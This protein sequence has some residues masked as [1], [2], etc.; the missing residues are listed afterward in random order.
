MPV[1]AA[2]APEMLER[3]RAATASARVRVAF[4]N[5]HTLNLARADPALRAAIGNCEFVLNDGAGLA[6]AARLQGR[7]FPANLHGSAFS[8]EILRLAADEGWPAFLLGGR[9]GVAECA[10]E[11]LSERIPGLRI[12][13][14][15]HGFHADAAGDVRAVGRSGARAL[16]VAMGNPLQELWLE[17]HFPE[18]PSVRLGAGVGAFLDFQAGVVRR[19]P[20]WMNRCG[21]EWTF[22]LAQEPRRLCGRYV[23]GNPRFLAHVIAERLRPATEPTGGEPPSPERAVA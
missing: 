22:R 19:S 2:S 17:S 7:R 16:L 23:L 10:A 12:A 20:R 14:T 15:R 4:V 18:L 21:I 9:S 11:R 13:G 1:L 8:L 5:A 6:L 3:I